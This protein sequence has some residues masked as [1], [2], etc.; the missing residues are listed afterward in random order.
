MIRELAVTVLLVLGALFML[1]SSLGILRMPDLYTRMSA[2]SKAASLGSGLMLVSVALH[3]DTLGVT[4]RA[5]AAIA[6]IFLT[7]PVATHVIGRAAYLFGIPLW[8]GTVRDDL[9]GHY[10]RATFKLT[11]TGSKKDDGKP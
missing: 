2:T 4:A 7:V 9:A 3:F 10:D 5:L 6:F 11:G 1:L 8:H